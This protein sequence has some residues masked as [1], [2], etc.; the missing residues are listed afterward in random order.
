MNA[1]TWR[2]NG[3]PARVGCLPASCASLSSPLLSSPLLYS[4]SRTPGSGIPNRGSVG[5]GGEDCASLPSFSPR[6][7]HS[8][9]LLAS[10][11][12]SPLESKMPDM[13]FRPGSPPTLPLSAEFPNGKHKRPIERNV[14]RYRA[15]KGQTRTLQI[16]TTRD[17]SSASI[18]ASPMRGSARMIPSGALGETHGSDKE[19][20]CAYVGTCS[21]N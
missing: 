14:E 3:C 10:W 15:S 17:R 2:C 20:L 1:P 4:P 12:R 19:I 18:R 6:V 21:R 5:E 13:C 16:P 8:G 11:L 7:P 9:K